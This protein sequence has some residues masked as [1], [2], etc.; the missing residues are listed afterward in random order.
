MKKLIVAAVLLFMVGVT[1]AFAQDTGL[2]LYLNSGVAMPG[3]QPRGFGTYWWPGVVSG[4]GIG[5]RVNSWLTPMI[6][7]DWYSFAR[8][9]SLGMPVNVANFT[10]S[11]DLKA[12]LPINSPV[13]PYL[14]GGCGW[15]QL[16][17]GS[18]YVTRSMRATGIVG[19]G[20]DVKIIEPLSVFVEGDYVV[21]SFKELE[22][23]AVSMC[24]VKVGLCWKI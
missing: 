3:S 10:V 19:V 18:S 8:N 4:C 22:F 23:R 20:V 24:P 7:C 1:V 12:T 15:S 16:S 5:Y 14:I 17:F 21:A 11:A 13:R 6:Y 2:E 9:R